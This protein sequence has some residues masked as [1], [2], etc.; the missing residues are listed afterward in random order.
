M[1]LCLSVS[2]FIFASFGDVRVVPQEALLRTLARYYIGYR[3]R[4]YAAALI[5]P[6]TS[7]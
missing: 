1:V 3:S 2:F 7:T 4:L 5:D 6:T